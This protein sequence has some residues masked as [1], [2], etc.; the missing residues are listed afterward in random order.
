MAAQCNWQ[1]QMV[2]IG[3]TV[4]AHPDVHLEHLPS[5]Q[6]SAPASPSSS[7]WINSRAAR[8]VPTWAN[9][10]A[11]KQN[12]QK[13]Q[14]SQWGL[15]LLCNALVKISTWICLCQ[16]QSYSRVGTAKTQSPRAET[17]MP[18]TLQNNLYE[19][20]RISVT[21]KWQN[22]NPIRVSLDLMLYFYYTNSNWK[23]KL[24]NLTVHTYL[25]ESLCSVSLH[26][27]LNHYL[28]FIH[29]I[30][31]ETK[32]LW[33]LETVELLQILLT[34]LSQHRA[35]TERHNC[36]LLFHPK[37]TFRSCFR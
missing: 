19:K 20:I 10:P 6:L 29:S 8:A 36:Q 35:L 22:I 14:H 28:H 7:N 11:R 27:R 5:R 31:L 12:P 23:K 21:L 34:V 3:W 9:S 4:S 13:T 37:V 15:Q 1:M 25:R 17:Q 30:F 18:S 26:R 16:H 24:D 33:D 32:G 2:N